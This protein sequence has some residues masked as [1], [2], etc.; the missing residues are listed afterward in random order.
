MREGPSERGK[1]GIFQVSTYP[2]GLLGTSPK[3]CQVEQLESGS[4]SQPSTYKC[5]R[6]SMFLSVS[7][8][9]KSRTRKLNPTEQLFLS[10]AR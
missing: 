10:M 9:T 8:K 2:S 7:C 6:W 4:S 5:Q 1:D 3:A